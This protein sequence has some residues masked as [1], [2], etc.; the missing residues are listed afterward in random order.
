MT[1]TPMVSVIMNCFNGETY[2]GEALDS[3]LAQ[4]FEDWEIVFWDNQST[5]QRAEIFKS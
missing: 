4:T 1:E 3:V 2:L 5:E